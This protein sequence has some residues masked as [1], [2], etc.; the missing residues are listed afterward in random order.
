MID[1]SRPPV[2]GVSS[3]HT[4]VM[5]HRSWNRKPTALSSGVSNWANT[6]STNIRKPVAVISSPLRLSGRRRH[7]IS[8]QATNAVPTSRNANRSRD[9]LVGGH[10]GPHHDGHERDERA[11]Q[12]DP[13]PG[14]ELRSREP[15]Q[16]QRGSP[17]WLTTQPLTRRV[18]TDQ[19][20]RSTEPR[21]GQP[22]PNK[23]QVGSG[24]RSQPETG[25]L[26]PVPTSPLR[27]SRNESEAQGHRC[28]GR[29]LE[30]PASQD[31]HP[32]VA[33]PRHRRL[34]PRWPVRHRHEDRRAVA[35]RRRRPRPEDSGRRL[36][37]LH[38]RRRRDRPHP[39][40]D[41]QG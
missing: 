7:A 32:P 36:P 40:Q 29:A 4:I 41:A 12:R 23:T 30:R 6:G 37:G 14:A 39:E 22:R 24:E 21:R 31:R 26:I 13:Q 35:P 11:P 25:T 8:P 20:V 18:C 15:A 38:H 10:V 1:A 16:R 28:P 19:G 2:S 34:L 17:E 5:L 33:G 9:R 27:R 3:S